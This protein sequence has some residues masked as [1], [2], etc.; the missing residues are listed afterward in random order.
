MSFTEGYN[1]D[2]TANITPTSRLLVGEK[3]AAVGVARLSHMAERS[4]SGCTGG[5][6]QWLA[7]P[8]GLSA[9]V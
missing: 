5:C 7:E 9:D 8:L 1:C 4:P 3:L 2:L 6:W